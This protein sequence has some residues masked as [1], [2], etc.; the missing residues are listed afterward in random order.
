MLL[1]DRIF[2]MEQV[3]RMIQHNVNKYLVNFL[4]L[5]TYLLLLLLLLLLFFS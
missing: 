1:I 3:F 2:V 5:L 4:I